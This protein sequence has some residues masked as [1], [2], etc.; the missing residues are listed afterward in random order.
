MHLRLKS[1][2]GEAGYSTSESEIRR[3][4]ILERCVQEH[5]KWKVINQLKSNMNT[6]KMQKDGEIR[7][8]KALNIWCGDIW[9][10]ENKL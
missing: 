9:Y 7:Y 3:H 2:L 5:G 4:A 10:V 6:K 8:A 1:F